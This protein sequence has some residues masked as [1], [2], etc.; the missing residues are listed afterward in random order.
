MYSVKWQEKHSFSSSVFI[1]FFFSLIVACVDVISMKDSER[2]CCSLAP[3]LLVRGGLLSFL[4]SLFSAPFPSSCLVRLCHPQWTFSF[5]IAFSVL[6]LQ[7]VNPSCLPPC[8]LPSSF[9]QCLIPSPFTLRPFI[10]LLLLLPPH[11]AL[12]LSQSC[13]FASF[14]LRSHHPPAVFPSFS[15]P[16]NPSCNSFFYSLAPSLLPSTFSSI[17]SILPLFLSH[18]TFILY[19]LSSSFLLLFSI[20]PSFVSYSLTS[21]SIPSTCFLSTSPPSSILFSP[22]IPSLVLSSLIFGSLFSFPLL[23]LLPLSLCSLATSPLKP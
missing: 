2:L 11:L 6:F 17:L 8:F 9:S 7:S 1:L 13:I 14:L 15:V 5:F 22:C 23:P 12:I 21:S 18:L 16:F 4:P 3:C 19:F 20:L 10:L